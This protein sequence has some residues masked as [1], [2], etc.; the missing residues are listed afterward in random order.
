MNTEVVPLVITGS[1]GGESCLRTRKAGVWTRPVP[2][3]G[4]P[5]IDLSI[6]IL[7]PQSVV[8]PQLSLTL[9]CTWSFLAVEDFY[10]SGWKAEAGEN[11]NM[12]EHLPSSRTELQICSADSL[13]PPRNHPFMGT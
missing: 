7:V 1:T 12:L 10:F 11:T 6:H 9:H 8:F 2:L 5:G 13:Y 4:L 3:P